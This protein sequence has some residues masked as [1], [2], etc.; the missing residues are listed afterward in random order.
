MVTLLSGRHDKSE[1]IWI[2]R[3][4]IV[5]SYCNITVQRRKRDLIVKISPLSAVDFF[6]SDGVSR[7]G[8]AL[9]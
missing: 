7:F 8:R 5:G 1:L 6:L 9:L 4:N 2:T 3:D